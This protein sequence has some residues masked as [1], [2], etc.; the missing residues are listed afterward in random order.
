MSHQHALV[1]KKKSQEQP[2]LQQEESG[3]QVKGVVL[4]IQCWCNQIYRIII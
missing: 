4:S 3:Q 2:V 1:E